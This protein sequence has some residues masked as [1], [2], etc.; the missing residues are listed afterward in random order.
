M[1]G[2]LRSV[3]FWLVLA[4]LLLVVLALAIPKLSYSQRFFRHIHVFDITQSMNVEDVSYKDEKI[5]RIELAK[6]TSRMALEAMPCGSK[7]GYAIFTEHRSFLLLAPVEV[8]NNYTELLKVLNSI[9]W[10]IAWRSRSEIAKGLSSANKIPL[11]LEKPARIIFFT[12]GH[13]SPPVH[14][15]LR[16]IPAAVQPEYRG[17]IVG[18][19]GSTPTVIPRFDLSG[20]KL[21]Y[22]RAE[23]VSQVDVYSRGRPVTG[24]ER[25]ME[26]ATM[27]S[28]GQEHL[29]FLHEDYLRRLAE[30]SA[31]AYHT[32]TTVKRT[33]EFI[34]QSQ[35]GELRV[36][37][38]DVRW[39]L[40]TL[41]LMLLTLVYSRGFFRSLFYWL[42]SRGVVSGNQAS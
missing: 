20:K 23:D 36:A 29:S 7:L 18:V 15:Q 6:L 14:P 24:S 35:W 4:S 33:A 42:R 37:K 41:S 11:A 22:W 10:Q 38:G 34:T 30:E 2:F 40:A 28:T 1:T 26:A 27:L 32:L 17:V 9:D 31:M 8:C 5:R 39:L 13:E 12:D 3:S 25:M 21:G 16:F 19:G